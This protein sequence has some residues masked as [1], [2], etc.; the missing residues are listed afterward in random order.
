M[1][2]ITGAAGF[3]GSCLVKEFN[4]RG[5]EDI[6]CVDRLRS[7]NKWLNLRGLKYSDFI[8]ADDL[9][10]PEILH[11]LDVEAIYHLGACSSTTE[12][13]VDYLL[14][15]NIEYSKTLIDFA[16]HNEIPICF[17]SSAAT[18]GDGAKGYDDDHSLTPKLLPLNAYGYSKQVVDE[19]ILKREDNPPH[20]YGVKFFNVYGPNEYHKESM[21]SVVYKAFEQIK[22]TGTVKLFKSHKDGF[23]DGEQKRD[24][25]Y[26]KDICRAMIEMIDKKID[27]GLYNLGTG[28][29]RTFIDLVNATF[30]ALS[31]ESKIEFIDMPQKL[32]G[33]YQYYTQANMSKLKKALPDFT[34][35]NLEEA[36][37]DYV[38]S[39][40]NTDQ[41]YMM[42]KKYHE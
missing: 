39:H 12:T 26:V 1:I 15:N 41:P 40:L 11:S 20:W 33:Q 31:I 23:E 18:Y 27:S 28:E 32:R 36:V 35:L 8:H 30:S 2:L 10:E 29:A 24:F 25:V 7:S 5:R 13:N 6:I 34:F 37:K 17:A 42:A 3:I 14:Y 22:E 19:W 38:V 21:T 9:L 4:D 16:T